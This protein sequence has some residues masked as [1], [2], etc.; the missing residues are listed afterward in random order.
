MDQVIEYFKALADA[1][2]L[3]MIKLLLHREF[4]VCELAAVLGTSQPCISQH[5]K[6][7]R[8]LGLIHERR[9]GQAIFCSLNKERLNSLEAEY[10]SFKARD[11]R[12]IPEMSG[13]IA[14]VDS[15]T[16]QG[17]EH[18]CQLSGRPC[19]HVRGRVR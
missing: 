3:K 8:R 9:E 16:G 15:L 7:L 13:E 4:A 11:M 10:E 19:P 2:R 18:I 12:L 6:R 5:L 17:V 14:R 1:T